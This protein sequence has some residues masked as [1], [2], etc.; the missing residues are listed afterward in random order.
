MLIE[1]GDRFKDVLREELPEVP[2]PEVRPPMH[3]A[4]AMTGSTVDR[5]RLILALVGAALGIGLVVLLVMWLRRD[6]DA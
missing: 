5:Q 1:E 3:V 2:P 4:P 6:E